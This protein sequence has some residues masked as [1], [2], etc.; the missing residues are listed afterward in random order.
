ML[1]FIF[2]FVPPDHKMA[3]AASG[4]ISSENSIERSEQK[5]GDASCLVFLYKSEQNFST[6]PPADFPQILFAKFGSYTHA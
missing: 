4:I 6:I 1:G 2:T 3:A 5:K